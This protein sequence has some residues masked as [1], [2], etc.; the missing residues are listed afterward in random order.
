MNPRFLYTELSL[1][2]LFLLQRKRMGDARGYLERFFCARELVEVGWN[3]PIA[4]IN[5]TYTAK[6]GTVRG[7]HFQQPPHA[8]KKLVMCLK[9]R[10]YDVAID[11]RKGSS[12]FLKWQGEILSPENANALLIPEGFAHGFQSLTP[13]VEMIYCHSEF[14]APECEAGLHS[15]DPA[16]KINW[17][18]EISEMSG[19]DAAHPLIDSAFEGVV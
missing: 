18:L 17:P 6:S 13:D 16:I 8:E 7:M 9:G 2:G 14:Y 3:V 15:N 5:L 10:V 12:T 11:I 1:S 19:R 4:Q